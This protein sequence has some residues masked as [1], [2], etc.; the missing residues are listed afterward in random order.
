[1]TATASTTDTAVT[2]EFGIRGELPA[3]DPMRSPHLLGPDFGW[4]R[5]YPNEAER[6][7][8]FADMTRPHPYYRVG[9]HPT[10]RLSKIQ[11]PAAR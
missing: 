11:R 6:D 10:L 5:W 4:E 2:T 9:D 3:G 7:R 8:A 1:M